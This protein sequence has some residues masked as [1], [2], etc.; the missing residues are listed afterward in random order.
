MVKSLDVRKWFEARLQE[1]CQFLQGTTVVPSSVPTSWA[2]LTPDTVDELTTA[3][4]SLRQYI[5]VRL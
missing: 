3:A 1:L 4:I 2:I 5:G